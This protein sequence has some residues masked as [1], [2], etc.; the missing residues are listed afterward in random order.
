MTVLKTTGGLPYVTG[1]TDTTPGDV[2]VWN[3]KA[4]WQYRH[5][6]EIYR[7]RENI[8]Q[9][10]IGR[11]VPNKGDKVFD[12]ETGDYLVS[13]VDQSTLLSTLISYTPPTTE[14]SNLPDKLLGV[15]PRYPQAGYFVYVDSTVNPPR[16]SFD[17]MLHYYSK[18]AIK[19]RVYAGEDIT[20]NPEVLSAWY[21]QSGVYRGDTIDL[22]KVNDIA[23][24]ADYKVPLEAWSKRPIKQGESVMVVCYS[25][26]GIPTSKV[27]MRAIDS[28]IIRQNNTAQREIHSIELVSSYLSPT[29]KTR[30][31]IPSQALMDSIDLGCRVTYSD[32]TVS[33][34]KPIDDSKIRLS[35]FRE[36]VSTE[37]GREN[38]LTLFY[39]LDSTESYSGTNTSANGVVAVRYTIETVAVRNAFAV[40]LFMYPYW[41]DDNNGYRLR[42]WLHSLDRLSMYDV[43]NLIEISPSS[44][45]WDPKGYGIKQHMQFDLDLSRVDPSY[46]AYRHTQRNDI[47]LV[48]DGV[49]DD[50]TA[51]F[52]NFENGDEDY[53]GGLECR[54]KFVS[55]QNWSV[56]IAAQAKTLEEWLD[57]VY[58]RTHPLY[59]SNNE[60]APPAPTH[61]VLV[62]DGMRV[63]RPISDWNQPFTVP[64]GGKVG[65]LAAVH[66]IKEVDDVDLQL[67]TS[68]FIIRQNIP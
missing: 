64:T 10:N 41:V 13:E 57:R 56:D 48:R 53:G 16:M 28:G 61:F 45:T 17:S 24:N 50:G 58:Y 33:P 19:V 30:L 52:V 34:L 21:D 27:V 39:Q 23:G 1:L 18:S 65:D 59:D 14:G 20:S 29:D 44:A 11:Y 4:L 35:G 7:G 47:S 67:G 36:Y 32:G 42:F 22:V 31:L 66:W 38:P 26:E 55:S 40:K 25:A 37:V 68:G 8:G 60:L 9:G 3:P 54:L 49:T 63:R 6:S 15:G 5:I 2:P 51:W 12:P 62:V 46:Q 43:T